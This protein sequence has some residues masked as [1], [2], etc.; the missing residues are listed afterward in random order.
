[1]KGGYNENSNTHITEVFDLRFI[2]ILV[3]VFFYDKL[4]IP[5]VFISNEK[6]TRRD[7]CCELKGYILGRGRN[8]YFH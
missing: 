7:I 4:I 1:V 5:G 3:G 8:I 2:D 6:P